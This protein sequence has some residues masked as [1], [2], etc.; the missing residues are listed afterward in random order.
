MPRIRIEPR[1]IY[2]NLDTTISGESSSNSST[3]WGSRSFSSSTS[4]PSLGGGMSEGESGRYLIILVC[5][6]HRINFFNTHW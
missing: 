6:S 2:G 1:L 4:V 3:S 5:A